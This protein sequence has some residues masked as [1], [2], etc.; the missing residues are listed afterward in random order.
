[1]DTPHVDTNYVVVIKEYEKY[2]YYCCSSF[3]EPSSRKECD[4]FLPISVFLNFL[5]WDKSKSCLVDFGFGYG[6]F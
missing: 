2:Y 3:F 4:Q 5:L 1:M 6:R